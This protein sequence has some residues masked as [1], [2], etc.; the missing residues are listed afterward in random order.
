MVV[1]ENEIYTQIVTVME[2]MTINHWILGVPYFQTN[3]YDKECLFR[4][5]WPKRCG[6]FFKK[7]P[8][9]AETEILQLA[10]WFETSEILILGPKCTSAEP[11]A[12]LQWF[13]ESLWR[14]YG[15]GDQKVPNST[16]NILVTMNIKLS[17]LRQYRIT[18]IF[19]CVWKC[20]MWNMFFI[21]WICWSFSLFFQTKSFMHFFCFL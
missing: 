19:C 12:L 20:G 1:S 17:L 15:Y 8:W 11:A 9:S 2:N 18:F 14:S 13:R 10:A 7:N 4:A 5:R 16:H 21:Q 3:P 6:K